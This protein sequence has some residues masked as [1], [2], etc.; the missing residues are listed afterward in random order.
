MSTEDPLTISIDR[1]SKSW[2]VFRNC[3]LL[4]EFVPYESELNAKL[5]AI[6]WCSH[7]SSIVPEIVFPRITRIE[8]R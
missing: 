7:H 3:E 4:K 2:A 6:E 5:A 8:C 1:K